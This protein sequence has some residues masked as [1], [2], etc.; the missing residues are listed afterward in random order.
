MP[1]PR[2]FLLLAAVLCGAAL[3]AP[4]FVP[5]LARDKLLIVKPH[6]P[7][8]GYPPM[9]PPSAPATASAPTSAAHG[10]E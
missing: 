5:V 6:V 8:A 7:P 3:A 1:T 9:V 2:T 4:A 10:R